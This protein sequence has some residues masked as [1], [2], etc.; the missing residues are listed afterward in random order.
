MAS[1]RKKVSAYTSDATR[2]FGDQVG[3]SKQYDPS[4]KK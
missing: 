2:I 4:T 3:Y 1:K